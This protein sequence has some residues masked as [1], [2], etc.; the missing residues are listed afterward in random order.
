MDVENRATRSVFFPICMQATEQQYILICV[1]VDVQD[2]DEITRK[3][4]SLPLINQRSN[5]AMGR[6]LCMATLLTT[7]V[8]LPA[9]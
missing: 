6:A 5:L 4:S 8:V 1:I 7:G 2:D 9:K 3:R